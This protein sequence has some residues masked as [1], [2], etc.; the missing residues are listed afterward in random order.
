MNIMQSVA[1]PWIRSK[2]S[3]SDSTFADTVVVLGFAFAG[4]FL[5]ALVLRWF[6]PENTGMVHLVSLAT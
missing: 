5:S 1:T 2:S 6:G 4:A 3:A